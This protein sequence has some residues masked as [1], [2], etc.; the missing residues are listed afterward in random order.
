MR[1]TPPTLRVEVRSGACG[2]A[3]LGHWFAPLDHSER[4]LT[5][6]GTVVSAD[7]LAVQS[8]SSRQTERAVQALQMGRASS[9]EP[10]GSG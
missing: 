8:S 9:I 6:G 5:A 1:S 2:S 7:C 10:S 4:V 3:L